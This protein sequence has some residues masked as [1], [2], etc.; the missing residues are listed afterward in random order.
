MTLDLITHLPKTDRGFDSIATFVD[1]LS[2]Y[3]YF[4]PC[5]V[6]IT[7]PE[8]AY[9]FMATVVAKHG[10]P[11][12]LISDCDPHFV[13]H[14]WHELMLVLGGNHALLMAYHPQMDG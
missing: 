14:F 3:T 7:A 1:W 13:S 11:H 4:V 10:M 6:H 12:K 2:K 8:L 9:I 5:T